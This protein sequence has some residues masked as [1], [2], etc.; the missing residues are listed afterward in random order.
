MIDGLLANRTQIVQIDG[1][2]LESILAT[3][4]VTQ[5]SLLGPRLIT[6]YVDYLP[7]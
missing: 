7:N 5:G 3:I 2:F 4:G 1:D 6:T